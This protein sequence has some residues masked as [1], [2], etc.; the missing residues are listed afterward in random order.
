MPARLMLKHDGI[1]ALAGIHVYQGLWSHLFMETKRG[2]FKTIVQPRKAI[3]DTDFATVI[4]AA[5]SK[6]MADLCGTGGSD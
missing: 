6:G 3:E 1:H 2:F 4:G 5:A